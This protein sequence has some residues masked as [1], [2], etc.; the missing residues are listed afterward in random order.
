ML[1]LMAKGVPVVSK[2]DEGIDITGIVRVSFVQ[3]MRKLMIASVNCQ[4]TRLRTKFSLQTSEFID[5][6]ERD[7]AFVNAVYEALVA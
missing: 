7:A 3:A 6:Q 5:A 4:M 2:N 1:E